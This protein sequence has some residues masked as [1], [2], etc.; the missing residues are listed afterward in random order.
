M[1]SQVKVKYP[2]FAVE[3]KFSLKGNEGFYLLRIIF[4]VVEMKSITIDMD[5]NEYSKTY[6][7]RQLFVLSFSCTKL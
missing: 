3:I 2:K 7:R 5:F 4:P 1:K 6:F